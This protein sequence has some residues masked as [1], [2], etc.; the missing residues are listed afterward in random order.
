LPA[1]LEEIVTEDGQVTNLNLGDY[2]LPTMADMP[3][4]ETVL[5]HAAGGPAPYEAKSIGEMANP[6]PPAA[7]ANAVDDAVRVRIY[8]LPIT[9]E[10]VYK[11][12]Q[13]QG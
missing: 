9:S 3:D 4:L 10:K 1:S 5:V 13:E 11:K 12:L 7:I 8:D 2:K 6:S